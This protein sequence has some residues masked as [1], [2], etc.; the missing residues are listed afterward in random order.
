[1]IDSLQ[2]GYGIQDAVS[3]STGK[4]DL[5]KAILAHTSGSSAEVYLHGG[6][7]TSWKTFN[8]DELFFLSRESWFEPGRPIRGG[9]PIVFPQFGG[10]TLPAHGIARTS[11]WKLSGSSVLDSGEVCIELTLLSDDM[12]LG[13]WPHEFALRLKVML[14]AESLTARL[15][16]DNSGLDSFDFQAV[17]HTYFAIGDIGKCAVHGLEGVTLIDSLAGCGKSAESRPAIRFAGETDRIYLSAPDALQID[18][19]ANGRRISIAKNGMADVVVWNPWVNKSKRISDLGDD[20]YL[21][22]VCVETGVIEHP[23]HLTP[24][25]TWSGETVFTFGS[26]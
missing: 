8:G 6:H 18:D 21:R 10:G 3:F 2:A 23:I 1:M 26:I 14:G 19:E 12:T 17:M 7:I 24:K 15:S 13:V 22:M 20:E 25:E 9:I 11:E 4:G 5:A 16:V